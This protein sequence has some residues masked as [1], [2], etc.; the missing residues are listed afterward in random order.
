VQHGPIST[1][2]SIKGKENNFLPTTLRYQGGRK[3]FSFPLTVG[4]IGQILHHI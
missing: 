4:M 3:L 2:Q 1:I